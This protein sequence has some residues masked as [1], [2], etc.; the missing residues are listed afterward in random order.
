MASRTQLFKMLPWT[1]GINTSL[2]ASM[3]P[4]NQLTIADHV[5]FDTRVSKKTRDGINFNW[6]SL[7][8]GATSVV[9]QHDFWF[10]ATTKTQKK[11]AVFSDGKV[12]SYTSSG[13]ATQLTV[14]G[15]AWTGT[16]TSACLITFNNKCFIAVS[17]AGNQM[18]YWDGTNNVEDAFGTYQYITSVS[19]ASSTTTK[20]LI[21]NTTF[22]GANGSTVIVAG[23]GNSTYNG[24]FTV[25][26]LST[27]SVTNDTITY[28]STTLSEGTTA[29][30]AI[31]IAAP[32]PLASFL[33]EHLGRIFCND[34]TTPDRLHYCQT[35]DNTLWNGYGDSGALDIFVGDGDPIGLNGITPTFKGELFVG[36][37]TKLYRLEGY[38]PEEF[39]VSKVSDS[40]GFASHSS[41]ASID[42]DDVYFVS[43]KG[44]H[45]LVAT[46]AY[47]DF[48]SSYVSADIQ[49]TFNDSFNKSRL[50]NVWGAYNPNINSV[51]FTF[52]SVSSSS[53]DSIY[54]Y[55]IPT[56][57]WYT[58]S[59]I[60]CQSLIVA[61]DS[62]KY[63]FYIG[64]NTGRIAKTFNGTFYDVSAAG[65][66]TAITYHLTTGQIFLDDNPYNLKTIRRLTLFYR[67][68]G[69]YNLVVNLTVDN[70]IVNSE[71]SLNFS[72]TTS[73][74]LV[75]ST[76]ITGSSL[77][78]YTVNMSPYTKT[79]DG[80]GRCIQLDI[81]Q[82]Q[83]NAS[84]E[85]QGFA[86]E[87]DSL[88]PVAETFLS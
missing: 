17:G 70:H 23:A 28:T 67:P 20:T 57:A 6:D 3:I 69:T 5:I 37:Q 83:T 52:S 32:A 1:G 19:R 7:T 39:F 79:V 22:P 86:I 51:T 25:T 66:N 60:S 11:V 42:Q 50:A 30:T 26:G 62:D 58:W 75:G 74:A 18:K 36:K 29:D 77:V 76:F 15:K 40:I 78:G 41:I 68:T 65:V 16:L 14:N 82:T 56:K 48:S 85:L 12:Y 2:D 10:G 44:V 87:Y 84:V 4:P 13:T 53:N 38:A 34:K 64:S 35:G 81:R 9:G 33:R 46:Q 43:L 45:S 47:G 88:G 31:S 8:S 55:N 27:T 72:D 24:T 80:V 54:L 63:R 21:F 49:K 61:N 59:G 73:V 71:N